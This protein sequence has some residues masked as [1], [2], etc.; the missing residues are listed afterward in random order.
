ME[1]GRI[2]SAPT[3]EPRNICADCE[4]G[5][6]ICFGSAWDLDKPAV[7]SCWVAGHQPDRKQ[8]EEWNPHLDRRT[9]DEVQADIEADRYE[10]SLERSDQ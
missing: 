9:H 3:T 10:R 4:R 6:H 1:R 8:G 2:V 7:C 5:S